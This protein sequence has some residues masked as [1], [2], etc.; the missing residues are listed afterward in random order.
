M[1]DG[2]TVAEWWEQEVEPQLKKIG[3][4]C[5]ERGVPF[6]AVGEVS[7]ENG[8][9]YETSWIGD[10]PSASI[11]LSLCAARCGG[12]VDSLLINF[13]RWCDSV[14]IDASSSMVLRRIRD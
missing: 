12:N 14:G 3:E 6:V 4:A 5:V 2:E 8:G 11:M 10:R 9:C 7:G 1:M 13:M